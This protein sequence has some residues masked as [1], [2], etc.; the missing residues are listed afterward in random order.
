MAGGWRAANLGKM[1]CNLFSQHQSYP[2]IVMPSFALLLLPC[3]LFQKLSY[4]LSVCQNFVVVRPNKWGGNYLHQSPSTNIFKRVC[5]IWMTRV[6]LT[7]T[8]ETKANLVAGGVTMTMEMKTNLVA[9]QGW[10]GSFSPQALP[11][12]R[13]SSLLLPPPSL[14]DSCSN[15]LFAVRF[16]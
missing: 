5:V 11:P 8:I 7:M 16:Q 15:S 1:C 14:S 12:R 6:M 10:H 4:K 9:R 2:D 3:F 13:H